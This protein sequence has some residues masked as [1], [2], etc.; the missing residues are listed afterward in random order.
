MFFSS[1]TMLI[2][3]LVVG[4]LAYISLVLLLRLSGRRTLSKMNA[5][6]LV[7][8]V[9][10]GST[11]AT[12]LLNRDVSL[13]EGVM[14]LALLIGLQYAVTWSSVRAAWIRKLVTG[15][16]A[17]LFYRGRFLDDALRAARVTED[18]VR[19]AVR[20]QGLAALDGIEAVVLETDG[21]FSVIT[22]GPGDSRSTLAGVHVP[23]AD[24]SGV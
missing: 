18:E 11:F 12:I 21:S 16:P 4:V 15:E 5:F 10:L 23:E 19:A 9:A 22:D 3:T 14:A 1:G 7:V 6:D 8:T 24:E 2:R 20:S 17:L 13:A